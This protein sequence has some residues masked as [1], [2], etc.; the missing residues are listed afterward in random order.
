MV[1]VPLP[2]LRVVSAAIP[3]TRLSAPLTV[4]GEDGQVKHQPSDHL[5]NTTDSIVGAMASGHPRPIKTDGDVD[6]AVLVNGWVKGLGKA[7]CLKKMAQK[8][9]VL[10]LTILLHR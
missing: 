1:L 5:Y 7:K 8:R 10:S 9:V 4:E 2:E 3:C 6:R